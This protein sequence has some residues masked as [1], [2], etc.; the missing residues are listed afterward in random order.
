MLKRKLVIE[1]I[2]ATW[3]IQEGIGDKTC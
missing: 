1:A 2:Q 3:Y